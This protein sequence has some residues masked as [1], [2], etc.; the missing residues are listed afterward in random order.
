[1]RL[2]KLF[3]RAARVANVFPPLGSHARVRL[4][5][6]GATRSA[7]LVFP[8]FARK[9]WFG[10]GLGLDGAEGEG[11]AEGGAEIGRGWGR[12]AAAFCVFCVF[13]GTVSSFGGVQDRT[14]RSLVG[15]HPN[16][17]NQ[18]NCC[19]CRTK[20]HYDSQTAAMTCKRPS[21]AERGAG[22]RRSCHQ[23]FWVWL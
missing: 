7:I 3:Q 20:K 1:M 13:V 15:H 14:G 4:V 5:Q 12:S 9:P 19:Q 2:V 8:V 16:P 22:L 6:Y 23:Y 10:C 18:P 21:N 17:E 11:G